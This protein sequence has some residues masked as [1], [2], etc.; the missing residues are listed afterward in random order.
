MVFNVVSR[1]LLNH[2][3]RFS[4]LAEWLFDLNT[5]S[6]K[7]REAGSLDGGEGIGWIWGIVTWIVDLDFYAEVVKHGMYDML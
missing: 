4:F 7:F 3:S 1:C 2:Q 5:P 6:G